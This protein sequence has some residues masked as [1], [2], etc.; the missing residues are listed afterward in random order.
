MNR[1]IHTVLVLAAVM[2]VVA[3]C[4]RV[5]AQQPTA[6]RVIGK[7]I[8]GSINAFGD[9]VILV[10]AE[11]RGAFNK[12]S[13][14][15]VFNGAVKHQRGRGMTCA[16]AQ[17][18]RRMTRDEVQKRTLGADRHAV[19]GWQNLSNG[20]YTWYAIQRGGSPTTIR[21]ANCNA[22]DIS[23]ASGWKVFDTETNGKRIRI[24]FADDDAGGV[25]W[26]FKLLN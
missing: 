16:D 1:S 4:Q 9:R 11:W 17:S 25:A 18:A 23:V 24:Q 22:S 15:T 5:N 19:I 2:F 21:F 26:V 6:Q 8:D 3:A 10:V 7:S 20:R 12:Q 14:H 13:A